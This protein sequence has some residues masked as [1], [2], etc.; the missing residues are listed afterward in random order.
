MS[1]VLFLIPTLMHGGAE[2]VLVNLVNNLDPNKYD[3]TLYSIFDGGVNKEF[4]KSHVKYRYKFKKVFRGNSQLMKLLLP[5]FLYRFFIDEKYDLVVSFLEG[6]AARIIAGCSHPQS[7]KIA[8][9]HSDTLTQHVAAV[10]FRNFAEAQQLYD[11]FD[12]IAGVSKNVVHSF[13][14]IL[15]PKVPLQVL[16]NVNETELIQQLA[17][18]VLVDPLPE[19]TVNICSV[20]KITGNKGFDRLLEVHKQLLEEGLFHQINVLGIGEDQPQLEK[21]IKELGVEQS[22]KLLGFHKNP[23][24]YMSRCDLYVCTS[25]REGFSTAVTE[26]LIV[27]IPVLSTEVSGAKELLGENNEYGIVT[28]NSTQGI[29]EGLKTL[30]MHPE[31]LAHYKKQ[32]LL[33]GKAFS[34]EKTVKAVEQLFDSL[35]HE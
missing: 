34:K 29:Y 23:Y 13:E 30:I 32:A 6:P 33:R 11:Q 22:F 16:Y 17:L 21:R 2:K 10:G 3:I 31:L 1:K 35:L 26:A 9:I 14:K 20:A 24:P 15:H 28:E 4:L 27:G 7:K 19:N 18:E 25:H 8:W 5:K 12:L